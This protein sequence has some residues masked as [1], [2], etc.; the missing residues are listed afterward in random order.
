MKGGHATGAEAGR[1]ERPPRAQGQM[2]FCTAAEEKPAL[3]WGVLGVKV[4]TGA[5]VPLLQGFTVFTQLKSE[6]G[7]MFKNCE[8]ASSFNL[9]CRYYL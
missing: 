8:N 2:A 3:Y 6:K 4:K 1:R 9:I 5:A 7:L